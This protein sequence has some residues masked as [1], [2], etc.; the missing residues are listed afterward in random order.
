MPRLRYLV[1]GLLSLTATAPA[2]I[3]AQSLADIAAKVRPSVVTV[4]AATERRV[5]GTPGAT[6]FEGGI[7]SGIFISKTEVLT[8]YHVVG[9][10]DTVLVQTA[11]GKRYS[12]RV[13]RQA[14]VADLALVEVLGAPAGIPVAPVGNSDSIRLA[15]PVFVTG[16]PLG[17]EFSVSSGILS[18]RRQSAGGADFVNIEV[19]QTDAAINQ[20]NSG[21]PLL[22]MKGEV[23]GVV[24]FILS[25]SGGSQGLGFAISS[26]T[27]RTLLIDQRVPWLGIAFTPLPKPIAAALNVPGGGGFLVEHV[28]RNS[29]GARAGLKGGTIPVVIEGDTLMIGGDVILEA[30]GVA[31]EATQASLLA[32]RKALLELGD[33]LPVRLKVLR[34]GKIVELSAPLKR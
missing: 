25:S 33:G 13:T 1:W 21:G 30:Q 14:Q 23:I 11:D 5:R 9:E 8:A 24:S 3:G 6:A 20:G 2:P 7:G 34:E 26:N 27:A 17:M 32:A 29:I 18:A 22:N 19:L 12:A 15:D 28:A 4:M 31:L 10:A 16:A